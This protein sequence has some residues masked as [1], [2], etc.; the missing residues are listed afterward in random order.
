MKMELFSAELCRYK[1]GTGHDHNKQTKLISERQVSHFSHSRFID[2]HVDT[3]NHLC[4]YDLR[5]ETQLSR[6]QGVNKM[7]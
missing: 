5:V 3:E 1:K 2:F 4:K 7:D 6:K